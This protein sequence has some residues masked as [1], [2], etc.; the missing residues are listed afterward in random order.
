MA[1]SELMP[2]IGPVGV[3]LLLMVVV[4]LSVALG[5]FAMRFVRALVD[6]IRDGRD[7]GA[8]EER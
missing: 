7:E 3:D 8:E 1:V 6:A 5:F 2:W 4:V